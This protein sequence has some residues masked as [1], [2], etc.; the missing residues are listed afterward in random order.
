MHTLRRFPILTLAALAVTWLVVFGMV[1]AQ[2]ATPVSADPAATLVM[3]FNITN[4][5]GP[6]DP[7]NIDAPS[8]VLAGSDMYVALCAN[9]YADAPI[10]GQIT[11]PTLSVYY[12]D[13][14]L[15]HAADNGPYDGDHAKDLDANPDYN[16][17]QAGYG[18]WD[19]NQLD[20][21]AAAPVAYPSNALIVCSTADSNSKA[22]NSPLLAIMHLHAMAAGNNLTFRYGASGD[23]KPTSI[24]TSGGNEPVC[25]VDITCG[26]YQVTVLP[27]ADLVVTKTG[28]DEVLAD[29]DI[30][31][32]IHVVNNGPSAAPNVVVIDLFPL[33]KVFDAAGSNPACSPFPSADMNVVICGWSAL[34]ANPVISLDPGD[35]KDLVIKAHV[36]PEAAGKPNL[37]VALANA[38]T[39]IP[40]FAMSP[41]DPD[42]YGL[43][44]Y[45]AGS[46]A[47]NPVPPQYLG[48]AHICSIFTIAGSEFLPPSD[49]SY[50]LCGGA[51]GDPTCD[52]VGKKL[53]LTTNANVT[54]TKVAENIPGVVGSTEVWDVTL[55]N[56]AGA[57]PAVGVSVTD[58]VDSNQL[59][60]G[61][62]GGANWSCGAPTA[63]SGSPLAANSVTCT[64][65]GTILAGASAPVL[66]VTTNVVAAAGSKCFNDA[67][68]S[69]S[70]PYIST[71][72]QRRVL[73]TRRTRA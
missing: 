59:I 24:L 70:D 2:R 54:A 67:S 26:S 15:G 30:S 9:N 23:P 29:T 27:A 47:C 10:S 53:T 22:M 64:L 42:F 49:P 73:S 72:A 7:A 58:T 32:N 35:S 40:P 18:G 44:N 5:T 55:S 13:T 19:C 60:T 48:F 37:N 45:V 34:Q 46:A 11:T 25:G 8:P 39:G 20:N 68:G 51:N 28:P 36:P 21:L 66:K 3:D 31:W 63:G 6:C 4:G 43:E 16:Q 50:H 61:A 56:A 65:T 12:D 69:W 33:D 38:T 71:R 14:K 62:A 41:P 1:G 52:N 17:A 57:S